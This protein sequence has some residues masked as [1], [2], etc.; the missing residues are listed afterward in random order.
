VPGSNAAPD[1]PRLGRILG[2]VALGLAGASVGL[3]AGFHIRRQSLADDWN[4]DPCE[5]PVGAT[6]AE[7]CAGVRDDLDRAEVLSIVGY[8][9]AG[10]FAA[11]GIVLF[12]AGGGSDDQ[13]ATARVACGVTGAG[14]RCDGRF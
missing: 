3:G 7:Q 8:A 6:R 2:G 12:A 11:T 14:L 10:A 4:G 5:R 1:E 9:L 13:P